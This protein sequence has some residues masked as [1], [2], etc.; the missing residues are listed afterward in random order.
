MEDSESVRS[1]YEHIVTLAKQQPQRVALV[2]CD[3]NGASVR[4]ITYGELPERLQAAAGYLS[5]LG[6][7]K[8]D[9]IA[10]AFRNSA[11]LLLLSW[12]A[13]ASG[14]VTVPLD[15]ERDTGGLAAYKIQVN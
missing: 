15:V 7:K 11:D 10:L 4:E 8:G 3:E 2:D 1:L 13:W 14:I 6:L 5:S 9:K 12:A